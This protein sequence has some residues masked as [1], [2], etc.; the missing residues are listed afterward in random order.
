MMDNAK[1]S[2]DIIDRFIENRYD[3]A[4][5]QEIADWLNDIRVA[6]EKQGRIAELKEMIKYHHH[7]A[8]Q[9]FSHEEKNTHLATVVVLEARVSFIEQPRET[10][11]VIT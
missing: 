1:S 3:N 9:S 8:E 6:I 2:D 11:P 7:M 4:V 5:T 10:P